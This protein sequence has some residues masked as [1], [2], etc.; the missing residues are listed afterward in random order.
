MCV[1]TC[2]CAE[3]HWTSV[4]RSS[5]KRNWHSGDR[6][7]PLWPVDSIIAA[8]LSPWGHLTHRSHR[9]QKSGKEK[10]LILYPN[11]IKGFNCVRG[12]DLILLLKMSSITCLQTYIFRSSLCISEPK[13]RMTRSK[14]MNLSLIL[15]LYFYFLF[16]LTKGVSI[17]SICLCQALICI[18]LSF[19]SYATLCIPACFF[20]CRASK[21]HFKSCNKCRQCWECRQT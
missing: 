14:A 11:L 7:S 21:E 8:S 18:P 20:S 4:H 19:L 6:G 12:T 16:F 15:F 2:I 3:E 1:W 17:R 5:W 13:A 10:K 9:S